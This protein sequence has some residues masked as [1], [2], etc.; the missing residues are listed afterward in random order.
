MTVSPKGNKVPS[1]TTP[2]SAAPSSPD[3]ATL[4]TRLQR[5]DD[6][7]ADLL[8]GLRFNLDDLATALDE[9][10]QVRQQLVA[11]LTRDVAR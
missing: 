8:R 6:A 5:I 7:T 11:L 1:Q 2:I 10:R 9:A 3:V 4:A